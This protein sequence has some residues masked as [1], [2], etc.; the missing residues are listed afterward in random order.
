MNSVDLRRFLLLL[1][2]SILSACGEQV[3]SGTNVVAR[4]AR[5]ESSA[6]PNEK[7]YPLLKSVNWVSDKLMVDVEDRD[8]CAGSVVSNPGY[9]RLDGDL[10]QLSWSWMVPVDPSSGKPEATKCTCKHAVRFE[11][12]K[13]PLR[14]YKIVLARKQ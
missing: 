1:A 12:S 9:S 2:V 10:V 3:A 11:L 7:P 4:W 14:D 5:C 13:L 8:Y 6:D